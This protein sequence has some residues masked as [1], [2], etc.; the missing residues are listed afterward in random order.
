MTST[1]A[2]DL[3]SE[4]V[5]VLIVGA[6]LSGIGA[7]CRLQEQLPRHDA[8]PI[9][10]A[11]DAIGGTW[12]L[13][14]Y[15]GVRSDSDMFTLGYPFRPWREPK[16]LADGASDPR[17]HRAST[18]AEAGIDA[19]HPLRAPG[20]SSADWSSAEARWTV[21][22]LVGA[23]GEHRDA[24]LLASSTSAPAT[25]TTTTATSPTSRHRA[26]SRGRLV[27]PQF[28]PEDLDYAGKRVV[29]IGSGA[30]AV[31]LVPALAETA[32]HVTMLQRSPTYVLGAAR[33]RPG[34]R[35]G[36]AACLPAGARAHG[37][38]AAKNIAAHAGLLPALPAPARSSP[39][40]C[41][42]G[43]CRGT[44]RPGLRRRALH[45]RRTTRGTSGSA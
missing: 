40:G 36:C 25:T 1:A 16:S 31:T 21:P 45:A 12:D 24:D 4:H 2:R 41:C 33:P 5:D 27:H 44:W 14:R 11:R 34:R 39:G 23:D 43:A 13:F 28:W 7:A 35:R 10:E 15:P 9:L 3:A 20:S 29:V 37:S 18:A 19:A 26:T 32:A 30:T 42:A 22:T 17:L 6:G 8:T 38:S